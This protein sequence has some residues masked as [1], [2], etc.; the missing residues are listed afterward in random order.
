MS[1]VVSS[2]RKQLEDRSFG[3][4]KDG[5]GAGASQSKGFLNHVAT[6][7]SLLGVSSKLSAC[8]WSVGCTERW[9]PSSAYNAPSRGLN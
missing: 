4:Q 5:T 6:D 2:R 8:G 1:D 3:S 7:G 9:M